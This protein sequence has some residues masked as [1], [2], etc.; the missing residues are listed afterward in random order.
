MALASLLVGWVDAAGG[1]LITL[2]V[3]HGLRAGSESECRQVSRWMREIGV[4]HHTLTWSGQKPKTRV[5]ELARESRYALMEKWCRENGVLHLAVAHTQ[6]DQAE[7]FLMRLNRGS[8]PDGLA[9][10]SAVV[11]KPDCRI[12]RPLLPVS[13]RS[14]RDYLVSA[15]RKWIEDPSNTDPRFERVQWRHR[16]L[17]SGLSASSLTIAADRYASA[18][19]VIERE[20]AKAIAHTLRLHS[21]GFVSGDMGRLRDLPGD[22]FSRVLARALVTVGA[23]RMP[24]RRGKLDHL[25]DRLRTEDAMAATLG[26]CRVT[27][28]PGR[29]LVCRENRNLPQDLA[30]TPG[31]IHHWD[32]R[33]TVGFGGATR[34]AERA[35]WLA[36]LGESGHRFLDHEMPRLGGQE[37]P[38]AVAT[39]LPA[40]V[41]DAGIVEIPHMGFVR[42]DVEP[43]GTAIR[44]FAFKP[45]NS[46]S[47]RGFYCC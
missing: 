9:A 14:L 47:G 6:E 46:L 25:V 36:P 7:T 24:P 28:Q 1:Q 30:V 29:L 12:L 11:E 5:Q 44:S 43:L 35:H 21:F 20:T 31:S 16:M 8:G 27:L 41:D 22:L 15:G 39:T 42:E 19:I 34:L 3:D 4:E 23:K 45:L 17:E 33:F 10:M 38:K 13:R 37:I 32:R 40:L 2:T 18:R 26:G